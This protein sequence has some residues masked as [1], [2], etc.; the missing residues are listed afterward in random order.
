MKD[1]DKLK[2]FPENIKKKIIKLSEKITEEYSEKLKNFESHGI[3]SGFN[4]KKTANIFNLF[5]FSEIR[6][7][8]QGILIGNMALNPLI[9]DLSENEEYEGLIIK[10]SGESP[11][12]KNIDEKTLF[13]QLHKVIDKLIEQYNIKRT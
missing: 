2:N 5:T 11:E 8:E 9:G 13:E 1:I 6:E 3:V 4:F 7:N 12:W 10:K